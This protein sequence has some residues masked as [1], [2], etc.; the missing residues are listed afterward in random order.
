MGFLREWKRRALA[1]RLSTRGLTEKQARELA[2]LVH[3]RHGEKG[4]GDRDEQRRLASEIDAWLSDRTKS[5][6]DLYQGLYGKDFH[7]YL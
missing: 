6:H 3:P 2:S 5:L 4:V 7:R 1:G